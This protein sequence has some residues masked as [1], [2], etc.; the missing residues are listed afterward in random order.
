MSSSGKT[1]KDHITSQFLFELAVFS[2]LGFILAF[3]LIRSLLNIQLV[4]LLKHYSI[5]FQGSLFD[6]W[7]TSFDGTK[8]SY[9][10]ILLVFG[11]GY[12]FITIFGIIL[13]QFLKKTR[14]IPWKFRLILTWISFVSANTLPAAMIGGFLFFSRFGFAFQWL[15]KDILY[16]AMIALAALILMLLFRQGWVTL[17]LRASPR[18]S[19]LQE[20]H[21]RGIFISNV[22]IKP[23]LAGFVILLFFNKP[24][25]DGFWPLFLLSIGMVT[26]PILGN[27]MPFQAINIR[28]SEKMIFTSNS[29]YYLLILLVGLLWVCGRFEIGF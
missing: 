22:F 14:N 17:F 13:A 3:L 5:H 23:M 25:I 18:R 8:W 4:V 6:T 9:K 2:T 16:R 21:L 11:S 1:E 19:F 20:D 28:R 15:M 7:F 29:Y 26:I 12:L 24:L 27:N 10:R